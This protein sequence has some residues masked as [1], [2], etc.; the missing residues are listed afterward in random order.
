MMHVR[1]YW[2][3][4]TWKQ[5]S[6]LRYNVI[7]MKF[8]L[9]IV[10]A[11]SISPTFGSQNIFVIHGYASP[12][13]LMGT[14]NRC[15]INAHYK[16]TNFKYNSFAEELDS[17]GERLYLEIKKTSVDT[18][19]FVTHSMGALVVRSML[20]YS[21][22]D[23][24]FPKIFRI[25]MI[26]PPNKGA[27]IADF[28]SSFEFLQRFLGPNVQLMRTDP[29]SYTNRL[30]IPLQA[31]IGI[32]IGIKG[33]GAG[34]NRA[35]NGDNDGLLTPSKAFLGTERDAVILRNEHNVLTQTKHV[36]RLILEFMQTGMFISRE[37][38]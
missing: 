13:L 15:L 26:A 24:S 27:E 4:N 28:F 17:I 32:I 10:L 11:L 6:T 18:V 37:Q 31:E 33:D 5:L 2:L 36:R 34:Y 16:T 38:K 8:V 29:T 22:N 1:G 3:N 19:S 25:V 12:S 21:K 20:Q 9:S 7:L 30:P 35:I 14:I 23:H